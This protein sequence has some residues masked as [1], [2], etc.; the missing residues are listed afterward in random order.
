MCCLLVPV[1]IAIGRMVRNPRAF[2]RVLW[3]C[4]A[5]SFLQIV[6]LGYENRLFL[7]YLILLVPPLVL[8]AV[9][10]FQ[11]LITTVRVPER[12]PMIRAIGL[13]SLTV[14]MFA[15]S[16]VTVVGLSG[17]TTYSTAKME[18]VTAGTAG[19]IGANTSASANV[20]L[21]G[22]DTNLYLVADRSSY[23]R[24][25]YEFPMVTAGY[26]SPDKTAAV[27]SE[28]MSSAPD[29]IVETPC[30]VPLFRPRANTTDPRDYDTLGPLR[31]FVRAHY[32][33]SASF[34]SGD[35]AED[36]YVYTGAR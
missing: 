24:I 8:L 2:D 30:T 12:G 17:L 36:V 16:S 11:W 4:M 20:F 19:W 18:N 3:I 14:C 32:R 23:D 9:P 31:D 35:M 1:A 27:L 28:W 10:G 29:V 15:V 22:N 21:W 25:V 13:A 34:G 6:T 5:W 7:H 33:I 26:W